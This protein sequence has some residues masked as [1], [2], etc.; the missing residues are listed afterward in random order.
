MNSTTKVILTVIGAAAAGA[1][2]GM[3][4]APEKGTELRKKISQAT[5][6]LT[7]Q[8]GQLIA[9]GKAELENLKRSA[10]RMESQ[11]EEAMRKSKE[12]VS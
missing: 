5:G 9:S 8:L 10:S 6:D 1:I 7:S 4:M 12:K 11:A 3:L 2:I